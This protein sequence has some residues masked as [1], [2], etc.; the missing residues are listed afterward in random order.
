MT[1]IICAMDDEVRDILHAMDDRKEEEHYGILFHRGRIA[2]KE[3][4]VVKCGVGKV[5]AA[6]VTQLLI[7][8]FGVDAI[9]NSGIAGGLGDGMAHGDVVVGTEFVQ[10][11]FDIHLFG[12]APGFMGFNIGTG[13]PD[14][15]TLFFSDEN[16]CDELCSSLERMKGTEICEGKSFNAKIWR[17]RIASG[18]QFICDMDLKLKIKNEFNALAVEME[19]AAVAQVASLSGVPFSVIR[20]ISDLAGEAETF[21]SDEHSRYYSE[22]SAT[23]MINHLKGL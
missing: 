23:L 19:G 3:L 13:D 15:P 2:D 16:L 5:N 17:G 18:D 4:V 6:R 12:Y 9:I 1:G 22:I 10:H 14:S 11:D 8:I 21:L 20:V 7:D